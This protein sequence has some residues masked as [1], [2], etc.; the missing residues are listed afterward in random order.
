[1]MRFANHDSAV[2]SDRAGAAAA[3]FAGV[4]AFLSASCCVAPIGLSILGAG[5]AGFALLGPLVAYRE[6]VLLGAGLVLAVAWPRAIRRWRC[7]T[8][9]RVGLVSTAVATALFLIAVSAPL[10]EAEATR[11]LLQNWVFVQ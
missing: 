7:A 4:L 10:W 1:M 6:F 5:G 3:G 11:Y 8:R 9:W 2:S